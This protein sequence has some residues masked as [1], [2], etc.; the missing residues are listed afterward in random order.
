MKT[1]TWKLD[2]DNP[3][4]GE[5]LASG[6]M[7]PLLVF[8]MEDGTLVVDTDEDGNDSE[9]RGKRTSFTSWEDLCDY[10]DAEDDWWRTSEE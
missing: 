6:R 10:F 9:E 7:L 5:A 3:F 2:L 1:Q 8:E 4:A